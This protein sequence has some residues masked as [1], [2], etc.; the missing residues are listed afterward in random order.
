M[1]PP[2][3]YRE[4]TPCRFPHISTDACFRPIAYDGVGSLAGHLLQ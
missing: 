4:L 1:Y 3:P 2:F